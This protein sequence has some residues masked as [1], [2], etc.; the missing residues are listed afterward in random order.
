M[1]IQDIKNVESEA[2]IIATILNKPEY[3][4]HSEE[5][6]P[7]HF[8]DEQNAYI[9][10]AI[11]ELAKRGID[12]I[13]AYNITNIL[14]SKE[15][16]KKMTEKITV[17]ALNELI[18]LS[19]LI[20]RDSI[21]EYTLLTKNV[22]NKALRRTTLKKLY[23]CE[24][25]CF[26]DS[27]KDLQQKIYEVLDETIVEFSLIDETP[28]FSKVV[29]KTWDKIKTGQESS[30][31]TIPFQFPTLNKYVKLRKKELVLFSGSFKMGKSMMLMGI[32]ADFIKREIPFLY[33]DSELDLEQ[34]VAR[35]IAHFCKIEFSKIIDGTYDSEEEEVIERCVGWLEERGEL[36]THLK[37]PVLDFET[38]YTATK[39][40]KH[41]HGLEALICD[42]IKPTRT[43]D[44]HTTYNELGY[45]VDGIKNQICS[46][47]DII[48]VGAVQATS[49]GKVA[50][51]TNIERSASAVILI[52]KKTPEEIASDGRECGNRKLI[53][54]ANRLGG[55][56]DDGQYID[57]EFNGNLISFTEAKQHTVVEPY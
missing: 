7:N 8:S 35:L 19:K 45:L 16:T 23:E 50:D 13:D 33:I 25:L 3:T 1:N 4:F 2:G 38:I 46:A 18:D 57:L 12:N 53:I 55:Q 6:K 10:Y 17:A 40:A 54:K 41:T 32:A 5:L 29:R 52:D 36:F 37:V 44:A 30:L 48:G 15:S 14:N 42:Y 28:Q 11:S 22:L 51:S 26:N 56:F 21:S 39:K 31:Y 20:A 34:F 27:E 49:T 47:M 24:R 43:G 9:Y